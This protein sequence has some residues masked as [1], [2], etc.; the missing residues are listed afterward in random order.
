MSRRP[1]AV[2][3]MA[4]LSRPVAAHGATHGAGHL[5][6]VGLALVALGTVSLV[7]GLHVDRRR[8]A[9]DPRVD[10]AVVAGALALLAGLVAFWLG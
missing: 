8:D 7:G 3:V 10:V 4:A 6:W 5:P 2:V 1:L 9:A